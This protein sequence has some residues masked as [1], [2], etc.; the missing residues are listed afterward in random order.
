MK[1]VFIGLGLMFAIL[2]AR[3]QEIRSSMFYVNIGG[4]LP[5]YSGRT[6]KFFDDEGGILTELEAGWG[7]TKLTAYFAQRDTKLRRPVTL[8]GDSVP[9]NEPFDIYTWGILAGDRF[10]VGRL[11]EWGFNMG[12]EWATFGRLQGGMATTVGPVAGLDYHHDMNFER[13]RLGFK[14]GYRYSLTDYR[15]FNRALDYGTHQWVFTFS[16]GK[17]SFFREEESADPAPPAPPREFF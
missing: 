2:P 1:R 3:A 15:V 9:V 17:K 14:A 6:A 8:W 16:M 4:H 12:L 5:V 13:V 11:S 7:A 10:W